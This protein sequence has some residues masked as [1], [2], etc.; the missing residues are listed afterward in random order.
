VGSLTNSAGDLIS[1]NGTTSASARTG[2]GECCLLCS[3]TDHSM[4]WHLQSKDVCR[5]AGP[6]W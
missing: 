5:S 6:S 2:A 3:C 4:I 1:G